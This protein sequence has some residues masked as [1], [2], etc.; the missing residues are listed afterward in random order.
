MQTWLDL[1]SEAGF[2]VE[3]WSYPVQDD[4][5][6]SYLLVGVWKGTSLDSS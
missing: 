3:K 5:R 2:E 4:G 6:E 1:I